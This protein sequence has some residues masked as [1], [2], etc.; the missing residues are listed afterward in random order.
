[1]H[2]RVVF[3]MTNTAE[4]IAADARVALA[5]GQR[6]TIVQ[7]KPWGKKP[8]GWPRGELLNVQGNQAA[9]SYDPAKILD[10]LEGNGLVEPQERIIGEIV[11][12]D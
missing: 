10:Y 11:T 3:R 8:K 6:I 9:Y 2:K 4:Q 7:P 12:D 5:F 1:M